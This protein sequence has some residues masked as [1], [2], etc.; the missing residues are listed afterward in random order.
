MSSHIP[1]SYYSLPLTALRAFEASARHTSYSRASEELG[2][3][4]GAVSHHIKGLEALLDVT[5]F[6]R[7]G[8]RMNTTEHR[9]RPA[10]H[11]VD[12][13]DDLSRSVEEASARSARSRT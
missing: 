4:H 8:G 11:S 2:L 7:K 9:Q 5:L 13:F 6:Q 1:M 10:V 12:V 3:T